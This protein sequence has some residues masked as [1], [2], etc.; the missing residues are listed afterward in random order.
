M[1]ET[2]FQRT[3]EFLRQYRRGHSNVLFSIRYKWHGYQTNLGT[4]LLS[5]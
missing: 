5:T 2:V 4:S 1:V 3:R